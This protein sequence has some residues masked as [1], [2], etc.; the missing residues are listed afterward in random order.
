MMCTGCVLN[1]ADVPRPCGIH[2]SA[3]PREEPTALWRRLLQGDKERGD[4]MFAW[5]YGAPANWW[6]APDESTKAKLKAALVRVRKRAMHY[7]RRMLWV[8]EVRAPA[9]GAH[10]ASRCP[11][12]MRSRR[13]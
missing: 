11:R 9:Q 2:P 5:A 8:A 3:G 4:V 7:A 13:R 1:A 12:W 6:N 10:D